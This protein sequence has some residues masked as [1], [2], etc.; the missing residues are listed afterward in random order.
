MMDRTP[1]LFIGLYVFIC[2]KMVAVNN[3]HM[4]FG[5]CFKG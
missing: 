3:I 2:Q 4:W 5:I 1:L